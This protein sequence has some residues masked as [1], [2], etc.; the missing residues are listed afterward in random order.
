MDYIM[1]RGSEREFLGGQFRSYSPTVRYL[2]QSTPNLASEQPSSQNLICLCPKIKTPQPQKL[3]RSVMTRYYKTRL[4][5]D[6][7]PCDLAQYRIPICVG[8]GMGET[9]LFGFIALRYV[10]RR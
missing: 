6:G 10:C 7:S 3:S 4:L 8:R 1:H 9:I 5:R 2:A